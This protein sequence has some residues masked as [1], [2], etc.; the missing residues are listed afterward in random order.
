MFFKLLVI[1]K[2]EDITDIMGP[3]YIYDHETE[4]APLTEE[5]VGAHLEDYIQDKYYDNFIEFVQVE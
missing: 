3:F 2:E 4:F 5:E 1:S